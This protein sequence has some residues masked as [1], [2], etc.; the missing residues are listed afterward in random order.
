M[1]L[2]FEASQTALDRHDTEACVIGETVNGVPF[3]GCGSL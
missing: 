1:R 2:R 3:E